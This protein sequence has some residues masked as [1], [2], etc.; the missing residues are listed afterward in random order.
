MNQQQAEKLARQAENL[1][2]R[3]GA[4]TW[5]TVAAFGFAIVIS[6]A[7]YGMVFLWSRI[8]GFCA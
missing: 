2:R 7:I 6:L 3:I 5:L 1:A 8:L 4:A